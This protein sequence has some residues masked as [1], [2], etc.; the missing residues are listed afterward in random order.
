MLSCFFKKKSKKR[1]RVVL[2]ENTAVYHVVSKTAYHDFRFSAQHK[3]M[4]RGMLE[5]QAAFCGVDV[6]SFC[7][8]DNHFHLLVRVN[9]E[10]TPP[11]NEVLLERYKAL[12]EGRPIPKSALT[13]EEVEGIFR[14]G[15]SN[16]KMLRKQ[17]LA[18]MGTLSVFVKELKQRFSIWYNNHCDNVGTI[19]CERFKSVLVEDVPN[20]LKLVSA[21]IDLNPVR[22]EVCEN[23][24]DYPFSTIGEASRGSSF[25]RQGLLSVYLSRNWTSTSKKY[26]YLLSKDQ[27]VSPGKGLGYDDVV[28]VLGKGA[29]VPVGLLLRKRLRVFSEGGVI[30]NADFVCQVE[31]FLQRRHAFKKRFH[32]KPLYEERSGCKFHSLY[33]LPMPLT[34]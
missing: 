8:L 18:R 3:Q 27:P 22:A 26:L 13:I 29:N 2:G 23:P 12:Y 1:G 14:E 20:V 11:S 19:W 31:A 21:Y 16:A 5:R 34:Y 32:P 24:E 25:A 6:L 30:G 9:Y 4:F 28:D 33:L 17:L 7:I 10:E 15:G